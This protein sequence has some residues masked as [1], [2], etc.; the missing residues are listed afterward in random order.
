[1]KNVKYLYKDAFSVIGIAGEGPADKGHEWIAP[2]WEKA[3]ANYPQIADICRKDEKGGL[4]WWG[5]MNDSDE[6]NQRW[7]DT[8]KYMPGCEADIDAVPPEG[9][10]KWVIPAQTYLV[11]SASPDKYGEIFF[12]VIS[13]K[14]N[15]VTGSIHEYYP[16]PDNPSVMELW[17]PVAEGRIYCQSCAMPLTV[18]E[19]FGTEKD[20]DTSRDYCRY[21]YTDGDFNWKPTF[22]EFVEDNIRFWRE[23]CNNDDEARARIMEVFPKLKRWAK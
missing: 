5:A 8:G 4:L 18:P 12:K 20:G 2:L 7:G 22:E 19:D 21:C 9:W 6:N 16:V 15:V 11:V 1:M 13:D 10:T 3:G 14:N 23:G 17:F